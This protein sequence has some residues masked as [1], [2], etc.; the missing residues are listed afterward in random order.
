[1]LTKHK[2]MDIQPI[3]GTY[4]ALQDSAWLLIPKNYM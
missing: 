4:D 1:M 2:N 3:N